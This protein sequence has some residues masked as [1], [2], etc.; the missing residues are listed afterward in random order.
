MESGPRVMLIDVD[1]AYVFKVTCLTL[2]AFP[3]PRLQLYS[4]ISQP[5]FLYFYIYSL[6]P[7]QSVGFFFKSSTSIFH[8]F[9]SIFSCFSNSPF[10]PL[11]L[12]ET[13]LIQSNSNTML[14]LVLLLYYSIKSKNTQ[15]QRNAIFGCIHAQMHPWFYI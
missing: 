14:Y 15:L 2:S 1:A 11:V 3:G 12:P 8:L 4:V 13:Q 9:S 6:V 10:H 7:Y 5:H